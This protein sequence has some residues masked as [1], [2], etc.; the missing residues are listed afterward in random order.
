MLPVRAF[1]FVERKWLYH[2][3]SGIWLFRFSD[4]ECIKNST[5][6]EAHTS[7]WAVGLMPTTTCTSI[8]SRSTKSSVPL[9]V[10]VFGGR[11]PFCHP[12]FFAESSIKSTGTTSTSHFFLLGIFRNS[13]LAPNSSIIHYWVKGRY[14]LLGETT[15]DCG[16]ATAVSE[17]SFHLDPV[18]EN[19]QCFYRCLE[20]LS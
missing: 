14:G 7:C 8:T 13:A 5:P 15:G 4:G 18:V 20:M 9:F 11:T 1:G 16:K 6:W 19:C 17:I 12:P 10:N 2:R 3:P